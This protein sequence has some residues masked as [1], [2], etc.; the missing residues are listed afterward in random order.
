MRRKLKNAAW[1]AA[2]TAMSRAKRKL[3][4]PHVEALLVKSKNGL[5]L[6]DVEDQVVGR[7][8]S[9]RGDYASDELARLMSVINDGKSNVL[10][11]GTHVGALAIALS[12]HCS[13]LTA[14]EANPQTFRL[15]ELNLL[16]NR[17]PNVRAINIAASDKKEVIQFVLNRANSGG[18]KRAP[19]VHSYPYFYDSPEV[20]DVQAEP[21]DDLLAGQEFDVILMDIEGSEY[22]A[23]KG[24][25]STLA[26]A[27]VLFV[28]FLPHHLKNVARVSVA[29]FVSTI[30]PHFRKLF[31]PSKNLRV[32]RDGFLPALQAMYDKDESDDGLQF[33][34]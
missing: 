27:R 6:V 10:V 9:Y 4:G 8:L 33:S 25:Q 20:I 31:I 1:I 32:T 14:I 28:E 18:S 3:I 22:F 29:E 34:R 16:I 2:I 30:A 12:R 17:C 23:L 7:R 26:S 5:L 15:L 21:L 13:A 11:V 19:A 24:M